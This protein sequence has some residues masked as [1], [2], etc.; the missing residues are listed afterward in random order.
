VSDTGT[1]ATLLASVVVAVMG[2]S[3]V[4]RLLDGLLR[5]TV[6]VDVYEVIVVENGTSQFG[7][8]DGMGGL[9]RYLHSG[10]PNSAVARNVGV[11][12]AR[13]RFLLLTDADCVPEQ[14]WI[15]KMT[16][17]LSVG[18]VVGVGGAIGKYQPLTWT[19]QYA[20]TVM[21]GQQALAHLPAL[22]LPYVAGANAGFLTQAIR[23]VSGFDPDLRSGNDVDLCY[24]LGIAGGRL[25]IVSD[26][27]IWHEDRPTVAAHFRR[28]RFYAIY[29]V[30]LFAKYRSVT[31]RR[32]VVDLYPFRRIGAALIATPG[33]LARLVTGDV[34]PAS[35]LVL[36]VVEAGGVL[37]GEFEGA[38]RFRQLYL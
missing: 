35:R 21:D 28:F 30:L 14:D 25:A 37:A 26:A 17:R 24:K 29:Q 2:D 36:Q 15:E 33:A 1:S 7:D 10:N 19:Q 3:R 20:I 23:D 6:S 38:V 13:G 22:N 12:A 32:M 8:V 31:G 5:Q 18:D 4:R 27:L 9:V 34:G 16:T 11:A